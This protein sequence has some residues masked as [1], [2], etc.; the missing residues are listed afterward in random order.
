MCK[1]TAIPFFLPIIFFAAS[2]C[3]FVNRPF[4]SINVATAGNAEQM[5]LLSKSLENYKTAVYWGDIA[6]ARIYF[7][8]KIQNDL[9]RLLRKRKKLERLTDI[10]IENILMLPDSQEAKVELSQS[11]IRKGDIAVRNRNEEMTWKFKR[12]EGGWQ[13]KDMKIDGENMS[14]AESIDRQG[15]SAGVRARLSNMN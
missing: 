7:S 10:Q 14:L 6:A 15:Q 11:F 3:S 8:P 5:K 2:S 4:E 12:F 1:N 13:L 9:A